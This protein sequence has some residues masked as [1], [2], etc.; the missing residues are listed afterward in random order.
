[1]EVVVQWLL[2][3]LGERNSLGDLPPP[4]SGE[5]DSINTAPAPAG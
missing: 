1:M 2:F 3:I 4:G 5:E